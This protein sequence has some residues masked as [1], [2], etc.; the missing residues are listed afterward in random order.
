MPNASSCSTITARP[1]RSRPTL[2]SSS[3]VRSYNLQFITPQQAGLPQFAYQARLEQLGAAPGFRLRPH[4]AWEE[5]ASRRPGCVQ[6]PD[7]TRLHG[8]DPLE[9]ALDRISFRSRFVPL[10]RPRAP[11]ASLMLRRFSLTNS[12]IC[13]AIRSPRPFLRLPIFA[14]ATFM[15]GVFPTNTPS[16]PT[17]FSP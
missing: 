1:P 14:T 7:G 8:G 2:W 16:R 12:G 9:R 11:A 10:L 15:S 13:S 17:R 5:C 3:L 6:L 4:R